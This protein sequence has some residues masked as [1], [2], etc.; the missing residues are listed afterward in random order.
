MTIPSGKPPSQ[1]GGKKR[2]NSS[3]DKTRPMTW[4]IF[5]YSFV[6]ASL[7]VATGAYI[8]NPGIGLL[9]ILTCAGALTIA[10]RYGMALARMNAMEDMDFGA[11]KTTTVRTTATQNKSKS[12]TENK[13]NTK[14]FKAKVDE[15]SKD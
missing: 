9:I 1:R 4:V 11:P 15:E 5:F 2:K 10:F 12:N 7:L 6:G 8:S 13:S 14:K 3:N